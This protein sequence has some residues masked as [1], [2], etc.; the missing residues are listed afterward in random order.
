MDDN[1]I[2]DSVNTSTK[3]DTDRIEAEKMREKYRVCH[4]GLFCFVLYGRVYLVSLIC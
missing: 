4:R 1:T 3:V 2:N